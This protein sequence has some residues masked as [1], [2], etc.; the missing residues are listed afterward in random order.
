MLT[1][2]R[3]NRE[4]PVSRHQSISKEVMNMDNFNGINENNFSGGVQP[5]NTA[6]ESG[7]QQQG[8]TASNEFSYYP[9]QSEPKKKSKGVRFLKGLAITAA[10]VACVAVIGAASIFGYTLVTGQD[11]FEKNISEQAEAANA[12]GSS[13]VDSITEE[14]A[15]REIR[16]VPTLE[17]LAALE[18]ALPIPEIVNKVSP[19]VVGVA[20]Q[21][22]NGTSYGTGFIISKDGYIV[23]NY[24]V[25]EGARSINVTFSVSD[26]TQDYSAELVGGDEQTDIA[27]LKIDKTDLTA[28]ELGKSGELVVGELAITIGN[29]LGSELSG[30]VTAGIISALNRTLTVEDRKM[31]LIQTDASINSGNSGGPL[32][33]SYG[34]V[35]GITSA[36]ISGTNTDNLGFA[37]PIDEALPIVSDLI[38]Y[39][40]VK[41]RPVVGMVGEDISEIYSQYYDIPRGFIVRDI[42]DGGPADKAGVK[43][44][45]I[46]IG[47]EGELIE[48]MDEFNEV[49][50]KFKAGETITVSVYRDDEIVDLSITLAEDKSALE[51]K[52]ESDNNNGYMPDN[53]YDDFFGFPFFGY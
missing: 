17:Q 39:G 26:D 3:T 52:N 27:V 46:V 51:D 13:P 33:N 10:S 5:S 25:I 36:K 14:Q 35:V 29:P 15:E 30:T 11:L 19:S 24:H 6:A 41:G 43:V 18:N 21:L 48:S 16:D 45:D 34:Q 38:E 8:E 1:V 53:G 32:I 44:G 12:G 7:I 50:A 40:Y 2:K 20:C 28:V 23:T 31:T 42:T 9:Q 49:K 37:I 22:S 47:I 4:K